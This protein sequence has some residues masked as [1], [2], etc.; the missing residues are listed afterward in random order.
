VILAGASGSN[1]IVSLLI[2]I[3]VAGLVLLVQRSSKRKAAK[4]EAAR[5]AALDRAR[6]LLASEGQAPSVIVAC[7]T[8]VSCINSKGTPYWLSESRIVALTDDDLV[9]FDQHGQRRETVHLGDV[10]ST[11]ITRSAFDVTQMSGTKHSYRPYDADGQALLA[12][13]E[14]GVRSAAGSSSAPAPRL[15][16]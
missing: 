15:A 14:H 9:A 8:P 12:Q 2:L 10:V 7:T 6:D 5:A 4:V 11:V 16:G 3:V 13:L 1:P